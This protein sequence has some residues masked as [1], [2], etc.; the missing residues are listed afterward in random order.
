MPLADI[1][2]KARL[3]RWAKPAKNGDRYRSRRSSIPLFA[4]Q[5]RLPDGSMLER[6][7]DNVTY[8]AIKQEDIRV[9]RASVD[10]AS[11]S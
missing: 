3:E 4:E 6:A 9:K 11:C 10:L 1:V 2:L 5:S 7:R 8:A